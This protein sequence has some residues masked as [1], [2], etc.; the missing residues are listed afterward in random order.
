MRAVTIPVYGDTDVLA[1]AEVPT[2]EAGPGE[3]RVRVVAAGVNP[4]DVLIREGGMDAISTQHVPGVVAG[5]E[6]AG[7]VVQTGAGV[8]GWTVGT[9]VLALL[10][11]IVAVQG[12]HAEEVVL[13]ASWLAAWPAG[14]APEVA[15]ALPLNG[16]TARQAVDALGLPA[17]STVAV[18]G[19]AGA[20]GGF[21]VQFA[22][23]AG[24]R[25][26]ALAGAEDEMLVRRLGAEIFVA[27][28][29]DPVAA[30]RHAAADGVDGV[31]DA[32]LLGEA[33]VGAVRPG[34]A[35]VGLTPPATP[36]ERQ[37]LRVHGLFVH[38]DGPALAGIADLVEQGQLA[39][40]DVETFTIEEAPAAYARLEKSGRRISTALVF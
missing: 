13:P 7:E 36:A 38:S 29:D 18:T 27:R 2:P 4:A 39:V 31:I 3:V 17:G 16:L 12:A 35:F 40:R 11:W 25:V 20:V 19:A 21:A 24:H 30:L 15:A 22:A 14:L 6:L 23:A 33:V 9:A 8:T 26:L 37:G 32:A 1:V 28:S 5:W 34:G 10:D